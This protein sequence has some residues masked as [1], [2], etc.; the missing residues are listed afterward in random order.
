MDPPIS[1]NSHTI[2]LQIAQ[3]R[4]YLNTSRPKV[5]IIYIL[6]ALGI[7]DI[8]IYKS[9]LKEPFKGNLGFVRN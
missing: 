2:E 6:G 4:S 5:G 7:H 3:S 1:G 8:Y 9:P